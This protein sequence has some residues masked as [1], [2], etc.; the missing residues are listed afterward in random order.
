[1]S[2]KIE[3]VPPLR[4]PSFSDT[5]SASSQEPVASSKPSLPSDH[6]PEATA[7]PKRFPKQLLLGGA[8]VL[9]C[10]VLGAIPLSLGYFKGETAAPSEVSD[11][12]SDDPFGAPEVGFVE[13]NL[14][15]PNTDD[16]F[17]AAQPLA[18]AVPRLSNDDAGQG[19]V[20]GTAPPIPLEPV[21]STLDYAPED[22]FATSSQ[23]QIMGQETFGGPQH[24]PGEMRPGSDSPEALFETASVPPGRNEFE[25]VSPKGS[26]YQPTSGSVVDSRPGSASVSHS[27]HPQQQPG[28]AV[29]PYAPINNGP[30]T[31]HGKTPPNIA[32][33]APPMRE[34]SDTVPTVQ[35][36]RVTPLQ[37]QP[38]N[39]RDPNR[40]IPDTAHA[41]DE[42]ESRGTKLAFAAPSGAHPAAASDAARVDQPEQGPPNHTVPPYQERREYRPQF[43]QIRQG[44]AVLPNDHGQ[45]WCEYD[46]TPYTKA[47]GNVPGSFPEQTVVDWVLRQTGT[48]AWHSD[49]FGILNATTETLYVYHTPEMQ[50][51]VAEIVDRF[52]N[53]QARSDAYSLRIISVNGPNW[54]SQGHAYLKP[55]RIDTP[56][57]SGWL[58]EKEDQN[59]LLSELTRRSDYK[60]LSAPQFTIGSGR[61]HVVTSSIPKN[62]TRDAQSNDGVWPGYGT[63]TDVI[64]E[65]YTMSFVP[66]SGVD[67]VSADLMIECEVL[68]VEKMTPVVLTVPSKIAPRQRVS[69]ESPQT[70]GFRL[71]E[72][73]RWPK[74][75]V[76]VLDLGTIPMPS[77]AQSTSLIPELTRRLSG[78]TANRGNVLL[79]FE[80][81]KQ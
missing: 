35:S 26:Q 75:K 59:R 48:Q 8:V 15:K 2:K 7:R 66:L 11:L 46:I 70:C 20:R 9:G 50:Q 38:F 58:L 27:P 13:E 76:L 65:G 57:V 81:R 19:I 64:N 6:E 17:V 53:P 73:I 43:A 49:P 79:F 69:I 25:T 5:F 54:L 62:Y 21:E 40:H 71:D 56:G 3:S 63:Q 78:G 16:P 12:E 55:I 18:A 42:P 36:A 33:N 44:G 28:G 22:A 72:Q 31:A 37:T 1:M 23:P 47:L 24:D 77:A 80:C 30:P 14:A 45:V 51:I 34:V 4:V 39:G 10:L 61:K 74:D 60:E 67:G 41:I 52:L 29:S 32:S 68:Q